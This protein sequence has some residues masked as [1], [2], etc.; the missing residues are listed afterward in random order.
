MTEK[1]KCKHGEFD[2][3][4]GCPQCTAERKAGEKVEVIVK[5]T[6][7]PGAPEGEEEKVASEIIHLAETIAEVQGAPRPEVTKIVKE[8]AADGLTEEEQTYEAAKADQPEL[9]RKELLELPVEE[10]RPILEKQAEEAVKQG[11]YE[12]AAET[13]IAPRP[14]EDIEAHGYFEEAMKALE[15]AEARVIATVEDVKKATDDLSIISRLKKAMEDRKRMHLD[16]LRAQAEAIRETY[17]TLMDPIAR[18]DKI[19]RDK[20]LAYRNE[21]ERLRAKA[22]ELNRKKLEVAKEEMELNGELSESVN[23]VEVKPT[24]PEHYRTDSATLGTTRN[25]KWE[26]EDFAKVSDKYK[27]LNTSMIGKVIRAG[28]EI[29]GIRAYTEDKLRVTGRK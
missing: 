27:V 5:V 6:A 16:P 28:G 12:P 7:P 22:E 13:A 8:P 4:E 17:S 18:A 15:Y 10:R 9:T 26:L 11:I 2:P 23:L 25:R 19:T 20:I 24:Q 1:M 29:P 3:M 14:G 21:Q